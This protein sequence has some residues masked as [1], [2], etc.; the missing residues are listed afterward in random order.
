MTWQ[1]LI[2]QK[3]NGSG[4]K[5]IYFVLNHI[6][7]IRNVSLHLLIFSPFDLKSLLNQKLSGL[8]EKVCFCDWQ[9]NVSIFSNIIRLQLSEKAKNTTKLMQTQKYLSWPSLPGM[10]MVKNH[11]WEIGFLIIKARSRLWK[12]FLLART[13]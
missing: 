4:D 7:L 2:T 8:K 9:I 5:V 1:H 10:I 12:T 11:P 13:T 6:I 3:E